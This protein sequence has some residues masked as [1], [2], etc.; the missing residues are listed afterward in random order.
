MSSEEMVESLEE[1]GQEEIDR[2]WAQEAEDRVRAFD[3]GEIEAIPGD[4][5]FESLFAQW[6]IEP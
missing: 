6:P 5:V 1:F 3:A 2:L 4:E